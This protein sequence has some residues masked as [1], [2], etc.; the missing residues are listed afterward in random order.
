MGGRFFFYQKKINF[1]MHKG[2]LEDTLKTKISERDEK[3]YC[4]QILGTTVIL[5]D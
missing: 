3:R 2:F 4:R 1:V 5:R